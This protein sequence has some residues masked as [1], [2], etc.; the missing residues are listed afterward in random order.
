M[1]LVIREAAKKLIFSG[2]STK[3]GGGKGLSNKERKYFFY[4]FFFLFVSVLLTTKPSGWGQ[5][6]LVDC[7]LKKDFSCGFPNGK[8]VYK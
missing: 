2:Q 7:S 4:F 3:R 6:A 5:K 1:R 8:Y